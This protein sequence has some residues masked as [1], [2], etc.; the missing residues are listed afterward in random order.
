M[1]ILDDLRMALE[2]ARPTI[3]YTDREEATPGKILRF[4]GDDL[5]PPFIVCHPDDLAALR[6]RLPDHR[7]VHLRD[8]QPKRPTTP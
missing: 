3:Y 4:Q 1:S 6:G 5:T 7:F 2:I 8:W